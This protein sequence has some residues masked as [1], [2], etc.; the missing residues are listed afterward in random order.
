MNAIG[1]VFTDSSASRV[2][3]M[4]KYRTFAAIPF[5]GRYRLIDFAVSNLANAGIGDVGII[6]RHNYQ[7][8]M[9]HVSSGK[10][11]DLDRMNSKI[12]ILPPYSSISGDQVYVNRLEGLKANINYLK[13]NKSKYV[14]ITSSNILYNEDLA[15]MLDFHIKSGAVITEMYAKNTIGLMDG[16]EH[17]YLKVDK[18][19]FVENLKIEEHSV[20]GYHVSTNTYIISRDDLMA[21]LEKAIKEDYTSL[22]K[23][24]LKGL[25][26]QKEVKAYEAKGTAMFIDNENGYL[27]T[28]FALLD[29]KISKEF[30]GN[31]ERPIIT[32]RKNS[33]PTKYLD[34]AVVSNSLISDGAIIEGTVKNSIIFR[35]VKIKKGA[36]VEN[37][38]I[39]QDSI[40]SENAKLNYAILDKDCFINEGRLLSGYIT[41]PFYTERETKI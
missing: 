31:E 38:V 10:V 19:G 7:S 5:G 28:S 13:Y 15:D 33:A 32:V 41:H 11:W 1:I 6:T 4:I 18:K 17:T 36:V 16:I 37:S 12:T 21:L 39:M 27:E 25:I 30:F 34:G 9:N 22:R 3:E 2:D 29:R 14:I 8:L 23:D 24:I 40:I 26:E 20:D 35:G